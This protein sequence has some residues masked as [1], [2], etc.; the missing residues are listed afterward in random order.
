MEEWDFVLNDKDLGILKVRVNR[1]IRLWSQSRTFNLQFN[2]F[3]KVTEFICC[4]CVQTPVQ[5]VFDQTEMYNWNPPTLQSRYTEWW[6]PW[7]KGSYSL[8][9]RYQKNERDL[10]TS[11]FEQKEY[12][13]VRVTT[14]RQI[15]STLN[16]MLIIPFSARRWNVLYD[17]SEHLDKCL[18][19]ALSNGKSKT[20]R[21]L[22]QVNVWRFWNCCWFWSEFSN[23]FKG[24]LRSFN[25]RRAIFIDWNKQDK[26]T[27]FVSM[28]E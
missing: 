14:S 21:N 18:L 16:K 5:L 19:P 23:V 15:C 27:L 4:F 9:F 2:L 24:A 8:L 20:F 26:W 25:H 7:R 12:L 1:E 13:R 11:H 6:T 10:K 17:M 28:T 22:A 3:K